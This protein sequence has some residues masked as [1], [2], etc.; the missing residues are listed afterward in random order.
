MMIVIRGG[1]SS[2]ERQS[3]AVL[4]LVARPL[5]KSVA[6]QTGAVKHG[7][8]T[9]HN[10]EKLEHEGQRSIRLIPIDREVKSR[11]EKADQQSLGQRIH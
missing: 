10:D 8:S 11:S 9:P 6:K 1:S 5:E 4:N 3:L 7:S 2:W